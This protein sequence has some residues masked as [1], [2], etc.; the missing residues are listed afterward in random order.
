MILQKNIRILLNIPFILGFLF[1]GLI[2]HNTFSQ[3]NSGNVY[4]FVQQKTQLAKTEISTDENF[5]EKKNRFIGYSNVVSKKQKK[6]KE[7]LLRDKEIAM[8][9]KAPESEDVSTLSL[10]IFLYV[11]DS[12]KEE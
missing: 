7:V 9:Q 3:D 2:S 1:F 11:L 5:V 8:R 4:N 10:N 6:S 12:F